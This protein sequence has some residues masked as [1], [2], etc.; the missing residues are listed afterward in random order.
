MMI[1]GETQTKHFAT[2]FEDFKKQ[3]IE[4][5]HSRIVK[6]FQS[7]GIDQ[8]SSGCAKVAAIFQGVSTAD[9]MDSNHAVLFEGMLPF[10]ELSKELSNL[11]ITACTHRLLLVATCTGQS[12]FDE[13]QDH[14]ECVSQ[15]LAAITD[16]TNPKLKTIGQDY[17]KK[18]NALGRARQNPV[19]KR[20]RFTSSEV[21]RCIELLNEQLLAD[22]LVFEESWKALEQMLEHDVD[23]LTKIISKPLS[24]LEE[25]DIQRV[26]EVSSGIIRFGNDGKALLDKH[27]SRQF[28]SSVG[29]APRN[30]SSF[31]KK[32]LGGYESRLKNFVQLADLSH[33]VQRLSVFLQDSGLQSWSDARTFVEKCSKL[34][35]RSEKAIQSVQEAILTVDEFDITKYE[36]TSVKKLTET[37]SRL[38][39]QEKQAVHDGDFEDSD[40]SAEDSETGK[41]QAVLAQLSSQIRTTSKL[42]VAIEKDYKI[43]RESLERLCSAMTNCQVFESDIALRE[44]AA[45][46]RTAAEKRIFQVIDSIASAFR[47]FVHEQNFQELDALVSTGKELDSIFYN[48]FKNCFPVSKALLQHFGDSLKSLLD[49]KQ[50]SFSSRHDIKD[51]ANGMIEVRQI[52]TSVSDVS[53]P[54]VRGAGDNILKGLIANLP[55]KIA[56]FELVCTYI[57]FGPCTI[58]SF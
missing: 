19:L 4:S 30:L 20:F 43:H 21:P 44:I 57:P 32:L 46:E 18:K 8:G 27:C 42:Q 24:N 41:Y 55:P 50:K 58:S 31:V 53:L 9:S 25:K 12:E 28:R 13:A 36:E 3:H 10:D 56:L 37:L 47:S 1:M 52:S 29:E 45:E 17:E 48:S 22:F 38:R 6:E 35:Q 16:Q 2:K 7:D 11:V 23:E 15:F 5:L 54:E 40:P 39:K 34:F 49:E 14:L 51:Y 26:F 33:T